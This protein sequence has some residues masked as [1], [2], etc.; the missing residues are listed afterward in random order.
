M[1]GSVDLVWPG[2]ENAFRLG[3]GELQALQT[4]TGMGP[5]HLLG[6]LQVGSW[7][8]EQLEAILRNGLIG[9]GMEKAEATRLIRQ[10]FSR[11]FGVALF[12]PACIQIM[13]AAL[14]GPEDDPVG[15]SSAVL[16]TVPPD[17]ITDDGVSA[18]ST[19][20]AP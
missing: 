4:T 3:I 11:G 15:E 14:Y 1:A 13:Q 18:A 5:E 6:L 16:E 19:D 10:T 9:G 12:K 17:L 2:G 8:V 7:K 20:L